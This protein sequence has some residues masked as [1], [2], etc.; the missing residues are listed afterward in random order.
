MKLTV[1][2]GARSLS[3]TRYAPLSPPPIFGANRHS[4]ASEKREYSRGGERGSR[5][6][7]AMLR[8]CDDFVS[9]APTTCG[10][11]H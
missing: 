10:G 3:A 11:T 7:A 5:H 8:F 2:C 9:A 6:G 1:A 4:A